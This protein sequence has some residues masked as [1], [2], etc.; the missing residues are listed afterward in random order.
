MP[1]FIYMMSN[2]R[3]GI[4]YVGVTTNLPKRN[5]EHREGTAPNP[6]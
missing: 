4:L 3:N 5:F 6:G 2:R 1:A